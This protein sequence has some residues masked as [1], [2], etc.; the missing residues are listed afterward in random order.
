VRIKCNE[1]INYTECKA[2]CCSATDRQGAVQWSVRSVGVLRSLQLNFEPL[3]SNLKA[4]HR[5]D[6]RLCTCLIV[7]THESCTNSANKCWKTDT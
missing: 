2:K 6:G 3:H 7:K 4:V 1:L 5:L